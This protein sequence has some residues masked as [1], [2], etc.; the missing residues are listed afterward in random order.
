MSAMMK[1]RNSASGFTLVE[2]MVVVAIIAILT[3]IAYPAYQDQMRKTRRSDAKI[4]LTELANR[5][6][7]FFSNYS[8]YTATITGAPDASLGYDT[9]Y[10]TQKYY[11]L[12]AATPTNTTFT[13]TA[14]AV[15]TG[16]QGGDTQ[17]QTMSINHIGA[18]TPLTGCW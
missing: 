7:K 16:P 2:L 8:R 11:R 13:V 1:Y 4:A 15:S 6:E 10:S 14:T 12:T 3:L 18:K 17:C 5:Q 9:D